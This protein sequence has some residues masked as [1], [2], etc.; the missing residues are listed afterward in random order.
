MIRKA[1]FLINVAKSEDPKFNVNT[2]IAKEYSNQFTNILTSLGDYSFTVDSIIDPKYNE[3]KSAISSILENYNINFPELLTEDDSCLLFYYF[4][5]SIDRNGTLYFLF[6]DSNVN[7]LSTCLSFNQ[8]ADE[9]FGY[10]FKNVIF[11]LDSCYSGASIEYTA[12][13]FN[14]NSNYAFLCSAIQTNKAYIVEGKTP[15]GVFSTLLFNNLKNQRTIR[16][17]SGEITVSTLFDYTDSLIKNK[18]PQD[19]PVFAFSQIPKYFGHGMND[20]TLSKNEVRKTIVSTPNDKAP[21]KSY[22]SKYLWIGRNIFSRGSISLDALYD[23]VIKQR[24][25]PFLTPISNLTTGETHYYPVKDVTF[26]T[27]INSLQDL[28][29]ITNDDAK[30]ELTQRGLRMFV[31]N[32]SNYNLELLELIK[33]EFSKSGME[34]NH[35]DYILQRR[36]S[37]G[38]I[39]VAGELHKDAKSLYQFNMNSNWFSILLDLLSYIGYIR[40]TTRKTYYPYY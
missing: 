13:A 25:E 34:V 7:Q 17:R 38:K 10:R 27:Y 31:D 21:T 3:G 29:I 15:F 40:L 26:F 8:V 20:F 37:L 35:L 11:I 4:G 16:N 12:R 39:P 33:E 1:I 36:M 28:H 5:H 24:P 9:F 32:E 30:L 23:L 2:Q 18:N 14:Q 22:Y 6:S 19:G